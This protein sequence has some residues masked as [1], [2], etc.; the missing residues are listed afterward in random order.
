MWLEVGETEDCVMDAMHQ[1]SR[2]GGGR[3]NRGQYV[4]VCINSR[5]QYSLYVCY[6]AM[7]KT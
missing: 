4:I 6:Q 1:E 3:I 2:C 7:P 5:R